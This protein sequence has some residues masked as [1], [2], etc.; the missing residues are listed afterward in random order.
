MLLLSIFL[1]FLPLF[2]A[3]EYSSCIKYETY[4]TTIYKMAP[5]DFSDS[6][7]SNSFRFSP[8]KM[9]K[10]SLRPRRIPGC[11]DSGYQF[12]GW[13]SFSCQPICYVG[14]PLNAFC[15][16]PNQCQCNIGYY[17]SADGSQCI[18]LETLF[19][20][21]YIKT[22]TDLV[23]ETTSPKIPCDGSCLS[24]EVCSDDVCVCQNGYH[25][26]NDRCVPKCD[27]GCQNADCTL[28]NN[29]T[30]WPEYEQTNVTSCHLKCTELS[31]TFGTCNANGI[32]IC[33]EGFINNGSNCVWAA[34][35][36]FSEADDCDCW[37]KFMW[38][39]NVTENRC[40]HSCEDSRELTADCI[41]VHDCEF[42]EGYTIC[43]KQMY[44]CIDTPSTLPS[45]SST[46]TTTVI[47]YMSD[48][49]TKNDKR[50]ETSSTQMTFVIVGF[51]AL[52]LVTGLIS[53]MWKIRRNNWINQLWN[54]NTM[55]SETIHQEEQI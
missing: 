43:Q 24:N 7:F 35:D 14:C 41:P 23:I 29:C 36:V 15:S 45:L 13:P 21:K 34:D 37:S 33:A 42:Y 1:S 19:S 53:L 12:K 38:Q 20:E 25:R 51:L 26:L 28:P 50:S 9:T 47:R 6:W 16:E 52:I 22:T 32:C 49:V 2:L 18:S 5:L 31:C 48:K 11:C 55:E 4:I 10:V 44:K 54:Y 17:K 39:T 30:C 46:T 27:N 8:K 3:S 40:I